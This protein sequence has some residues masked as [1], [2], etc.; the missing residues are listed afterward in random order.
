MRR[1]IPLVLVLV[2]AASFLALRPAPAKDAGGLD[3]VWKLV[4]VTTTNDEGT[5]TNSV[6]QPNL[7]IFTDGHY[8][9]LNVFGDE[10]R[11]QLP[12][13]PSDELVLA[14]WRQFNANAGTYVVSGSDLTT[15]VVVA[16]SPNA[17]ANQ[18]TNTSSFEL[19]GDTLYRTFTNANNGNTFKLKLVRVE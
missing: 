2:G 6:D 10:P 18:N 19:D 13:D 17:T 12:D 11:A 3:G 1:L 16:K 5:N 7:T 4:E 15:T 9:S 8:A 14:A